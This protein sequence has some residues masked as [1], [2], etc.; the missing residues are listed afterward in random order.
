M[1]IFSNKL[2]WSAPWIQIDIFK[3]IELSVHLCLESD[4]YSLV[5]YW[6]VV[7]IVCKAQCTSRL[8]VALII[9]HKTL[10]AR[11]RQVHFV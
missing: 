11:A 6:A 4:I 1:I 8:D 10:K 3:Y 9:V 2:H 7:H 5:H